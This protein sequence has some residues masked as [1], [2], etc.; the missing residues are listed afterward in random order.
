MCSA[1]SLSARADS[2]VVKD[3]R[4]FGNRAVHEDAVKGL[5]NLKIGKQL[6]SEAVRADVLAIYKSGYFKDVRFE[7]VP[8]NDGVAL[9]IKLVE[10]PSIHDVRFSGFREVT[11]SNLKEK[12]QTKRYTIVDE[13]KVSQDLRMIEQSYVEKGY[14]LARANYSLEPLPSGEV[15]LVFSIIENNPVGLGRVYLLGNTFLSDAELKSGM[16]TREKRWGSWLSS[17]SGTFKDEFVLRDKEYLSWI[18]RDTG[19]AEANVTAPQSRLDLSRQKV[20]VSYYIEEGERFNIG[21]VRI[22]GDLLYREQYIKDKL[23]L[24]EG[25]LYRISQIQSDLKF[26]TDLYGD[27][28]YAFVDV[29]PRV[30]TNRNDRLIDIEWILTKGEKVYFRNIVIEGNSK[31]R[32]NVVR[33]NM[34]F[35]E[36]DRF[37]ATNLEKSRMAIER[38]GYFQEVQIL[39]EPD[40]KSRSMD[41]RIR[42]KEKMTGSLNAALFASPGED[43]SINFGAQLNYSDAN[44]LGKGWN[45]GLGLKLTTPGNPDQGGYEVSAN[46]GEPS[47]WDGPWSLNLSTLYSYDVTRPYPDEPTQ[48]KK[49][50]RA[51]VSVG[52]EVLVEDL[53]LSFGYSYERRQVENAPPLSR[54]FVQSGDTERFTQTLSFDRTDNYLMP[55]SGYSAS[56][57]HTLGIKMLGGEHYFGK[58]DGSASYYIP[59]MIGDDLKT[60]F[61]L[62]VEP[63]FAYS[64]NGIEVPPWERY[65]LGDMW[66]MKAYSSQSTRITPRTQVLN[67]SETG[68]YVPRD[69]FSGGNRSYYGA[70]EY[71]FPI[72][73]E[74]N[75]RFV[76][77]WE[78]G[79]VLNDD[80]TLSADSFKHDL[81]FGFRW[82]TPIAPFRFEWAWPY[83]KGKLGDFEFVF[84]IGFDNQ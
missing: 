55:T 25:N 7:T 76:T 43:S 80:E 8:M 6:A 12:L 68:Q 46:V 37:H 71:F 50:V 60:N 2:P 23:A 27:Q 20:E 61:R 16:F 66:R 31:T 1:Y 57:T 19:Y 49:R 59:I 18:Y 33:R 30:T 35:A 44:L 58:I 24:K 34:K 52:R 17:P 64:R 74:A 15:D 11:E 81:G 62:T 82:Q 3:I 77:F 84:S 4:V 69:E 32:D 47:I 79:A 83:E 14:Y 67:I 9:L 29:V 21:K 54:Y 70:I 10:K 51:G 22:R 5:I 28:G 38:L 78:S 13:R 53:R 75:L 39:R 65:S 41:I 40:A 45:A 48:K 36:G 42:L 26:L 63:G 72:I 56:I 73:Q